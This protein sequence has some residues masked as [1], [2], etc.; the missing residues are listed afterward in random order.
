ML[1]LLCTYYKGLWMINEVYLLHLWK[2]VGPYLCLNLQRSLFQ[3]ILK[4]VPSLKRNIQNVE[5]NMGPGWIHCKLYLMLGLLIEGQRFD[6]SVIIT[7][8]MR[9]M[10]QLIKSDIQQSWPWSVKIYCRLKSIS[11]FKKP[12]LQ[13][14]IINGKGKWSNMCKKWCIS[15]LSIIRLKIFYKY[16][17]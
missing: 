15:C 2:L 1:P 14:R 8:I 4:Q 17:Y 13:W 10:W 11:D 5:G 7:F 16:L 9:G 6:W 12:G 3:M